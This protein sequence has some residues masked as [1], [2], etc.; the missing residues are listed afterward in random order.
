MWQYSKIF[1]GNISYLMGRKAELIARI[2]QADPSGTWLSEAARQ[3]ATEDNLEDSSQEEEETQAVDKNLSRREMELI[4]RE[5]D[6]MQREIELLRREN[7]MLRASPRSSLSTVSRTTLNIKNV[8]DL[9]SEC[10]G[11]GD[12]F[13]RWKAQVNLLRDTYDLDENAAKILVGS[14]LRGKAADWYFS[15]VEHLSMRVDRL[16]EKMGTMFNQSLSRLERK[17]QFENRVWQKKES[18]S[19]YCH[20]KVIKGNKV[21]IAEEEMVDYIIEGIP[22]KTLK[23]QAKMHSFMTVQ[24]LAK[25][26]QRIFLEDASQLRREGSDCKSFKPT[27]VISKKVPRDSPKSSIRGTVRCYQC[28]EVGHYARDCTAANQK[29]KESSKKMGPMASNKKADRQVGLIKEDEQSSSE[30][31]EVEGG[32]HPEE[33]DEIHFVDVCG[34][35]RDEFQRLTDVRVHVGTSFVCTARIRNDHTLG[36]GMLVICA[37]G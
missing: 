10:N 7:D 5:R 1:Y 3:P 13:E 6:L 30:E 9:F 29:M 12:D 17:L 36:R 14:K 27:P 19:D 31:S 32:G 33:E 20:D 34:E 35:H 21:P 22:S 25:A 26:F 18:F 8:S 24:E 11:F 23:N 4:S 37:L 16:M 15:L 2:Q 28:G